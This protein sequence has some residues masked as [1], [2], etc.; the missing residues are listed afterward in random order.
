MAETSNGSVSASES[1][2]RIT[3]ETEDGRVWN[4]KITGYTAIKDGKIGIIK[5]KKHGKQGR[6]HVRLLCV[7]YQYQ[8]LYWLK[9][10]DKLSRITYNENKTVEAM[11]RSL[12]NL[13]NP[14]EDESPHVS[15]QLSRPNSLIKNFIMLYDIIDIVDGKK[16]KILQRYTGRKAEEKCCFSII[17][18]KRTLDLEAQNEEAARELKSQLRDFYQQYMNQPLISRKQDKTLDYD[19]Q[20]YATLADTLHDKI[21][22]MYKDNQARWIGYMDTG[23][24]EKIVKD[25]PRLAKNIRIWENLGP[26]EEDGASAP[27]KGKGGGDRKEEADDGGVSRSTSTTQEGLRRIRIDDERKTGW[28]NSVLAVMAALASKLVD[29]KRAEELVRNLKKAVDAVTGKQKDREITLSKFFNNTFTKKGGKKDALGFTDFLSQQIDDEEK[30]PRY[31]DMYLD[32]E[33]LSILKVCNQFVLIPCSEIIKRDCLAPYRTKD[34]KPN[35]WFIDIDFYQDKVSVS[36][37]KRDIDTEERFSFTYRL[38]FTFLRPRFTLESIELTVDYVD[39]TPTCPLKIQHDVRTRLALVN[40]VKKMLISP[41][42]MANTIQSEYLLE[43]ETPR[44]FLTSS[45]SS[46][47]FGRSN[48]RAERGARKKT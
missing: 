32:Y 13:N 21:T 43:S 14:V 27:G 25:Y 9:S 29:K 11:T 5:V 45:L 28:G 7:D 16:T 30:S 23:A 44:S 4:I 38:A 8:C 33:L 19:A 18:L 20:D 40:R 42:R 34:Y 41:M 17:C 35:G 3:F 36:Q 24:A 48:D 39:F 46:L 12:K 6:P 1:S 10:D 37:L 26:E 47:G 15:K 2:D 31:E 22:Q